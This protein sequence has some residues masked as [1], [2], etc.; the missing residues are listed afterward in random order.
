L[1]EPYLKSVLFAV[2]FVDEPEPAED[3]GRVLRVIED[4]LPQRI[5]RQVSHEVVQE[6]QRRTT[7]RVIWQI[8]FIDNK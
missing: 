5:R 4:L 7:G 3:G 1:F 8:S 6:P 2:E